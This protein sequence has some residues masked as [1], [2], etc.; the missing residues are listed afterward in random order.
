MTFISRKRAL[1]YFYSVLPPMPVQADYFTLMALG[2]FPSPPID[3]SPR[4]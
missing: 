3:T 2:D 4:P 1:S